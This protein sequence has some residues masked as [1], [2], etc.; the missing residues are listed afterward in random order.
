MTNRQRLCIRN[1]TVVL[2]HIGHPGHGFADLS[3][4]TNLAELSFDVQI[5][6]AC[7]PPNMLTSFIS[8][9]NSPVLESIDIC[10]WGNHT[11]DL[12]LTP[13]DLAEF[14]RIILHSRRFPSLK[15]VELSMNLFSQEENDTAF[16]AIVDNVRTQLSGLTENNIVGSVSHMIL[17]DIEDDDDMFVDDDDDDDEDDEE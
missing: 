7:M 9:L 5:E 14:K 13:T 6:K 8:G 10:L 1:L 12:D 17:S 11:S 16:E 2:L 15:C 3:K 4:N